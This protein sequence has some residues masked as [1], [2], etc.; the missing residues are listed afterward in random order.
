MPETSETVT[1]NIRISVQARYVAQRSRPEDGLWFFAYR[2][3]LENVGDE[4][5]QL[6]SRHWVITDADARVEEVR[7]PGVVGEQPVL[8]PGEV[9]HYTSACP[10]PTSFGTMH[11]SYQMVTEDGERFDATI[12][13]FALSLPHAIH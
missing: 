2:V 12:A 3:E 9:F 5:V 13:P 11:G 7:G 1:R 6:L 4:T 8:A 10:L